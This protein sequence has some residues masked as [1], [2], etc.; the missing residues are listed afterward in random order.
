MGLHE[1]RDDSVQEAADQV[2]EASENLQRTVDDHS[3][4]PDPGNSPPEEWTEAFTPE[5]L[6]DAKS[7]LPSELA[8]D[9]AR[10]VLSQQR[11]GESE[12]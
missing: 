9:K 12:S 1:A 4:K 2:R 10:E 6:A 11:E 5:E 8:Q 7:N 3:D